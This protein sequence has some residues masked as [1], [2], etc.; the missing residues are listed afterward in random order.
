MTM[1]IEATELQGRVALVTGAAG[2]MG[3]AHA[4]MMAARGAAVAIQDINSK[5]VAETAGMIAAKGGQAIHFAFDVADGNAVRDMVAETEARLGRLDILV[6]NA[7]IGSAT[8]I[9]EAS[10]EFLDRIFAVHV[11]PAFQA[12]KAA[13]PGM[14]QRRSGKIIN[15]SSRWALVGNE[16]ASD[17]C[18]AKAALLGLT[19]AW[20]KELAPWNI[21]VNAVAPGGVWS[22]MALAE[23]DGAA[24]IREAEKKVPLGRW[25]QPEEIA[26]LVT[27]LAAPRSDF[28]TGQVVSPNGGASIV[29]F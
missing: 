17:Y 11:T 5:G 13:I 23:K 9:E 10:I 4:V 18:G 14:K 8:A 25:A 16:L 24:G 27:F 19:K 28:I 7:G 26:H 15:I 22:Q 21:Q 12:V 3:R 2:G 29:G 20:A 1:V 6:N